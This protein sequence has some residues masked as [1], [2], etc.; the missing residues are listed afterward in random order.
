MKRFLKNKVLVLVML[1]ALTAATMN[2]GLLMHPERKGKTGGH[3]DATALVLDCLWLFVG[4]V[5][6]VVAL[7]V[8]FVS[9]GIYESGMTMN[10][11]PGQKVTLRLPGP[12]PVAAE[13]AITIEGPDGNAVSLL[14]RNVSPGE[15]IGMMNFTLPT[16]LVS[17]K[18]LM[19]LTVND[20]PSAE[21]GLNVASAK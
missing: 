9:G 1:V 11:T 8:D 2:C 18:Y 7:A 4:V 19:S 21:W 14:D 16:E 20:V 13:V 6:G 17:G 15:E 5:P 10:V 12:A 3:I